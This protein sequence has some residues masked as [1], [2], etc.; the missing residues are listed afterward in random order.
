MSRYQAISHSPLK[1]FSLCFTERE[2]KERLEQE[3][4]EQEEARRAHLDEIAAKQRQREMEIDERE[5]KRKEE[6][7]REAESKRYLCYWGI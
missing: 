2:E 4:R 3:K 7:R 6:M 1:Q 5:A